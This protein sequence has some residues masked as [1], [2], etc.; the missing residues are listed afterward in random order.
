MASDDGYDFY[1]VSVEDT[2][3]QVTTYIVRAKNQD[4][5]HTF[6]TQ[7]IYAFESEREIVDTIESRIT[8]IEGLEK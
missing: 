6:V 1:A 5:A 7:G 4:Q 3:I 8:T 2:V